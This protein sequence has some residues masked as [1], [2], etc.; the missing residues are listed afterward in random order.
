MTALKKQ[1]PNGLLSVNDIFKHLRL[2]AFLKSRLPYS[3]PVYVNGFTVFPSGST[4]GF[5]FVYLT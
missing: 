5:H 1:N 3:N 2:M 4:L